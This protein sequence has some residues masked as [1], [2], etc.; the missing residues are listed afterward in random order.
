MDMAVMGWLDWIG[1]DW[2]GLDWI[3]ASET[4]DWVGGGADCGCTAAPSRINV[5]S[6]VFLT[7]IDEIWHFEM[8]TLLKTHINMST[9]WK[10]GHSMVG[11]MMNVIFKVDWISSWHRLWWMCAF[12]GFIGFISIWFDSFEIMKQELCWECGSLFFH[13]IFWLIQVDWVVLTGDWNLKWAVGVIRY[14]GFSQLNGI[15]FWDFWKKKRRKNLIEK[16]IY[17]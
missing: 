11:L 1:L 10:F 6:A 16:K 8:R 4:A 15:L 14:R 13:C 12:M 3:W 9:A 17:Q 5:V 2:I 7:I